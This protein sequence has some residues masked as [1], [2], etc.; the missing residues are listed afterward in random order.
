M[1]RAALR[2]PYL[3]IVGILA[4]VLL[5]IT[6]LLRIPADILPIFKTPAVQILTLYPG[7]PTDVMERDIA[8]RIERWTSQANGVALQTS[9]SLLGVSVVRDFFRPDIDP[10]TAL[11][12]V[13]SLAI[14]DLYYMPPGTIPPMVMPY[15][16]TA[17]IP[18]ALVTVS[19]KTMNET[20][21]YDIAY[22]NIR[23]M[24]SGI[25]G[26][27]APA[28]FGGRIRRILVYVDPS[29]LAARG[30]SPLDVVNGLQRWNTLIPTGDAKL[31]ATD[32]MIVTNG[33][34]PTVAQI[35]NFPLKVVDGSPVLVKDIGRAE[36]THQI[37]TN[38]VHINGRRQVYIPIYRQPGANT[39]Q[40]AEGVK[41]ALAGIQARIPKGVDLKVIFDQSVYVRRSLASL[42]KEVLLGAML[43]ALMVL[44]F[45]GS[46]RFTGVVFLTIPLSIL[47]AF[48][49]LYATGNTLN[50]MT[51]GG[52]ALAV[53]RLVD[54]SIVV[55]E[56]TVRHLRMGKPAL[57]AAKDAAEEVAMPVIVSTITTVVV[58]FP[59][60]FI[61]GLGRF[62]FSPLALSVAFAMAASYVLALTLIPA[63]SSRFL[64]P[65]KEEVGSTNR[66]SLLVVVSSKLENLKD[67]YERWLRRALARRK[68][69][70]ATA[71]LA[72]VAAIA[73]YS[74]L[75]KELFPPIDAGQFTILIHGP[76]G[77]RIELSEDLAAKV[78]EAA[79]KVIP[80]QELNTIVTNTGV[81]YDWPA[82]YTP[83]AGPM[84]SF[85]NVQ[86]TENHKV[87]A[88]EYVSRLRKVLPSEFPGAGFAFDTGGLLSAALNYGLP[89]PIDIQ[90][91]GNSLE[92]GQGIA[93]KIQAQVQQVPGTMDVRIQE[94]LDY[95]VLNIDVDRMKAAYLGLT[96]EDV[97]KNIE[98][99]INSSVN[100]LPAFWIDENNGN[101]YF[102]GAQYP[103]D[104]IRNI[105]TLE[106]IPLTDPALDGKEEQ[107]VT[108]VKNIARITRG[109]APVEVE[110]RAITRVTDVYANVSGRD[111][112][113]VASNIEK[114]LAH[115]T[116]PAGYHVAMRGEVQ[117]MRESFSG[118]GFGLL[119]AVAL[120]Y[121]VMVA[122][123]RSFLDPLIILFA[124]PLGIIGVIAILLLTGTTVNIQSYIGAI[125]MVGIAVSNSILLVEF[126]NRLRTEGMPVYEAAVHAGG[127]RLR[128]ILMTSC[129]AIVGLLPMAFHIGTGSEANVPLARAVIGGLA[130]STVLTLF[131]VP[132]LYIAIKSRGDK[133]EGVTPSV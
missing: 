107:D 14:S 132:A 79:R 23:N 44:L 59:V 122:Q 5:G 101:H 74:L 72:F 88:Q 27:I 66:R 55:L 12:Q 38:V 33:M 20:K 42:E 51:L 92:V 19:S 35:N 69:I 113:S 127:I 133:S 10:N 67:V 120:V 128:P 8:N 125:F 81:L 61:S 123:F 63:Y 131:V 50:M 105:A 26:T 37:Q 24:L 29:K 22:F 57:V 56:N 115:V 112:G 111:I 118:L 90:V 62:L 36:D 40:V 97:V 6:L 119:M 116:L 11:S 58:F 100:F 4:I 126:A 84:D 21:L 15:D 13:S 114:Q 73:L 47:A 109:I 99:A 103:E 86:L 95:P 129:A 34:V 49:G 124:V 28:V 46:P 78:E 1:V 104:L 39:I 91:S 30:L 87:S 41:K 82:A 7:M 89:S 83:N 2:N 31:G 98:I 77:M 52:L 32:Y 102:L 130:A 71:G 17:S 117:S 53:G 106:N 16:P 45:L 96:Q 68:T 108:L 85:M 65:E 48:I 80:P 54:D 60:V 70:L 64:H 121:L 18:L 43:A 9:K 76:S 93:R 3:V 110:H 75:G 25:T 94:K